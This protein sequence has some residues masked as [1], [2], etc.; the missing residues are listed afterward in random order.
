METTFL[1]KYL[2]AR[3]TGEITE[4]DPEHKGMV[5]TISRDTGCSGV[6]I[7]KEVIK[8]LNSRLKGVNKKHPWKFVSKEIFK[9]SAKKL[10]VDLEIFDRIEN[11]TDRS[12]VEE[13]IK[14]FSTEKYPS[15]FKIRKT[16]K[17]VI[18]SVE[19]S[20]G[21]V[22]LGRAGVAIV[23][24][25][26]RNLHIKLTAPLEW[27]VSKVAR[28]YKISDAKAQKY[29]AE[30]DRKRS[31]FKRYFMRR[32]VDFSDYDVVLNVSTLTKREICTAIV[33]MIEEKYKF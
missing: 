26:R 12:F 20:G 14:S 33:A 5:I 18:Q 2:N 16:F 29:V 15:E 3:F 21:V 8:E 10:N 7:V 6:P 4:P 23:Q 31:N 24:H 1:S 22:I 28:S 27:R 11:V 17:E 32:K 19:K 9:K 25:N 30:S 13:I